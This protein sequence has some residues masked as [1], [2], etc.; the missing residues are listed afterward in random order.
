MKCRLAIS[1]CGVALVV[2][3][4]G[5]RDPDPQ[6][7]QLA[8]QVTHEQAQQNQR[9]AE[10]SRAIA[11]GSQELV[12]ADAQARRDLIELQQGLRH[13]QTDVA[14]QRDALEAERQAVA[15]ER[16]TDSTIRSG[17]VLFGL[18]LACLA[19]LVLA[20]FSLLGLWREPTREEEG[21][22][23]VEQLAQVLIDT[24]PTQ[25]PAGRL[26]LSQPRDPTR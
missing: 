22:I 18:I 7:G 2:S 17:L 25:L 9:I 12:T 13:D 26:P 5:C 23:L 14:R 21:Q 6:L 20:G 10:G 11:Q 8:S 24:P 15:R 19:P 4:V 16:R 3:L 1:V